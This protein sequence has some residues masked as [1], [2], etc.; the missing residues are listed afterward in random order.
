MSNFKKLI[1]SIE[2]TEKEQQHFIHICSDWG[3]YCTMISSFDKYKIM[4]LMKY[5]LEERPKSKRLLTR[6]I[7]RFNRLN[8]VR[9]EVLQ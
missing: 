5:L 1:L 6:C 4:K 2:V 7:G 3:L 9:K 8:A